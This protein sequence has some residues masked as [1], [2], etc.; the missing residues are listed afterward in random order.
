MFK[1][2]QLL[3]YDNILIQC[4]NHPDPDTIA[5]AFGV[6]HYLKR[7]G[8]SPR[9]VYSGFEP[10]KKR[11]VELMVEWFNIPVEHVQNADKV[12][13]P[14]LL[15]CMDC[16]YG[17]GNIAKIK[18]PKVAVIDHH[19]KVTDFELGVIQ[20]NLG[21]CSTLVWTLLKAE[22]FDF[23]LCKD[24]PASLYYGLL[25]D[26]NNFSEINHPVDKDMR[27]ALVAY[28]DRGIV[29][30]LCNC[31]LTLE[32]LEI[33]GV[34]LLRNIADSKHGVAIFKA[35]QCDPNILGFIS[36][37]AL[38]V[39][40]VE[41]CVVYSLWESSARLSARSCSREVMAAEYI[42]Y[43]T[44]GVG[45]GGG[46]RDKAGGFIQKTEI[47]ALGMSISEY[48]NFKT[49]EYFNS[50]DTINASDYDIDL[51]VL[52]RYSKKPITKG[53]VVSTDLFEENTPIM[54]RTLEQ[55]SEIK[56]SPERYFIVG[57]QGEVRPITAEKFRTYYKECE[58]VDVF[59]PYE[60]TVKNQITG[61]IK[62]LKPYLRYCVPVS[63]SPI[64]AREL[65][66]NTKVF[67]DW[68]PTGY[69]YGEPGDFLAVKCDDVKDV[70]I[71]KD[72]IFRQ[73]YNLL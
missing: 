17:E 4:H 51:T 65:T 3:D 18:A 43:L 42:E 48:V 57:V 8:K 32:E 9:I 23:A 31:N 45:S 30:R 59:Y 64:Y 53:F 21:S 60:P 25:T 36:D 41:L 6:Y 70:Y 52:P 13:P 7:A 69:A 28:C 16:Q 71:I 67:T 26:T 46:H 10:I 66:R 68:N 35:E 29:R 50:Y 15:V 12:P 62:V 63:E 72:Y 58:S 47:D 40:S 55:D 33:A 19:L 54:V 14:D 56:A 38:Q 22:D 73:T 37:I 61:E 34:A 2:S 20:S 1:L 39:D 49:E 5:S 11:N 24:V 44:D 27:D